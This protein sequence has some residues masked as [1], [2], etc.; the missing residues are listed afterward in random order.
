M[1]APSTTKQAKRRGPKL[2]KSQEIAK[3]AP[4]TKSTVKGV[5]SLIL[6]GRPSV[7]LLPP[8]VATRKKGRQL[9][10]RVGFVL[11]G[12]IVLVVA[13]VG[14]ASASLLA[15]QAEMTAAQ[16]RAAELVQQTAKYSDVTKVQ[17]DVK[18]IQDA[19]ILG[20][21][22]EISWAPFI[23]ELQRTMP[24]SMR[25]YSISA[26]LEKTSTSGAVAVPLQGARI[27]TVTVTV[28]SSQDEI[29]T[30]LTTL[31]GLT[32]FVDATPGSV[33]QDAGVYKT[34]EVIH[35]N[36]KALSGRFTAKK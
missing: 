25:I 1:S 34:V 20:T 24:G 7:H 35:I 19:Q 36:D 2:P 21:S 4:A 28:T 18:A 12:V 27:A 26:D 17:T 5:E 32:G 13:G 22:Q 10:R 23:A 3:R 29:S 8:E 16:S 9:R 11:A 33:T 30:W 14:L 31:P 6:G 15:A